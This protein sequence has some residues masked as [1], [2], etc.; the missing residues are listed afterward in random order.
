MAG[1]QGDLSG[2]A[3]VVTGG[4]SGIGRALSLALAGE[5]AHV[6][7]ADI[8]PDAA[9]AVASEVEDLGVR[10]V[11]VRCDV[12]D[13]DSVAAMADEAW[14]EF[15][16]VDLLVN[17]AGVVHSSTLVETTPD[18]WDW[19]MGVNGRG[20]YLGLREF[21]RRF[22]EQGTPSRILTTGSEH[23]LGVPHPSSG[24]YTASKHA[25]L[26][27]SDVLRREVPGHVGVS[28]LC[29]GLVSTRLWD[30]ERN[31]APDDDSGPAPEL[32][33]MERL[34][35]EGLEPDRLAALAVA[36]IKRGDFL[37]VTHAHSARFAA[38]RAEE[39]AAAFA[40]QAP[41]GDDD[42]RYDIA[43]VALRLIS[44]ADGDGQP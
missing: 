24:I 2:R 33:L 28:V 34:F 35:G 31:R 5:G 30:A 21:G 9:E 41:P 17:N 26:A 4:G 3:A 12:T 18:D 14:G 32:E 8:D 27:M 29:P 15:G 22:S 11:A 13:P 1:L 39:V 23:S 25:V 43:A 19:V 7:A 36:G 40:E 6:A 38:E 10:G 16:H 20:A 44:E 42:D 37:I